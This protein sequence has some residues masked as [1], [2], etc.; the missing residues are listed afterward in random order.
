M[1]LKPVHGAE[2]QG[3][4]EEK[5]CVADLVADRARLWSLSLPL[6]VRTVME[7]GKRATTLLLVVARVAHLA[8]DFAI[9]RRTNLRK[10]SIGFSLER[11]HDDLTCRKLT[12]KSLIR[13]LQNPQDFLRQKKSLIHLHTFTHNHTSWELDPGERDMREYAEL[14]MQRKNQRI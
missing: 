1:P 2:A 11:L 13:A 10:A 3:R 6:N 5:T 8:G 14:W 7:Q 4:A 9:V 12:L